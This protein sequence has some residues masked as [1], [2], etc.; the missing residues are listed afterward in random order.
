MARARFLRPEFFTD[1][2]IGELPHSARLL[3][4]SIWC[5]SDLRGVFEYSAKQLRVSTFP[6]DEGLTSAKVQDWLNALEASGMIAR[7]ESGGKTWGHVVNWTKHQTISGREVEID[8]KASPGQKRPIPPGENLG[9]TWGRPGD[10]SRTLS[11]SNSY[12]YSYADADADAGSGRGDGD[13]ERRRGAS[14]KGDGIRS[15]GS[16]DGCATELTAGS[17]RRIRGEQSTRSG[18]G[19]GISELPDRHRC[20]RALAQGQGRNANPGTIRVA[21]GAG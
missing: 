7:F 17:D 13:G 1:E 11:Y 20:H 10:C 19:K 3:F 21:S 18:M 5:Q 9:T 15:H 16:R 12:S 2:K 4:A 8:A 14:G 6:Y